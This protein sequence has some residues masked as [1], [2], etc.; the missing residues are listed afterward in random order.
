[1]QKLHLPMPDMLL[2]LELHLQVLA[3]LLKTLIGVASLIP[4]KPKQWFTP[5][6]QQFYCILSLSMAIYT[7]EFKVRIS[8]LLYFCN[9]YRCT[10]GASLPRLRSLNQA[11]LKQT[12]LE[13]S[14]L[15]VFVCVAIYRVNF[16]PT[17]SVRYQMI[18]WQLHHRWS[19]SKIV[20]TRL[21]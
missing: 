19:N 8:L 11:S 10:G 5:P 15:W 12:L 18:P 9:I 13:M 2:Y 1:M 21:A 16:A 6:V 4:T 3:A 20:V 17:R 14:I 7:D